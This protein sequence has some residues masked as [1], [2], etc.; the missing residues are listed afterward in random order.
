MLPLGCMP[1]TKKVFVGVLYTGK[2]GQNAENEQL[3][4]PVA[5]QQYVVQKVDPS[6]W[7][8]DYNVE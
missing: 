6:Y 3:W 8:L 5:P 4:C 1:R 7:S 2:I